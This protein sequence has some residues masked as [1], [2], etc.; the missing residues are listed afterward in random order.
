MNREAAGGGLPALAPGLQE[1]WR[2][3]ADGREIRAEGRKTAR[4]THG[5]SVALLGG[6]TAARFPEPLATQPTSTLHVVGRT[7][8][9]GLRAS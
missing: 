1:A 4:A 9:V 7:D 3:G 2:H 6:V 5:T 8:H